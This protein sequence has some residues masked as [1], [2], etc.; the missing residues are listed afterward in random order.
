MTLRIV[1][2][3]GVQ[4]RISKELAIQ[5]RS[6]GADL[7]DFGEL[8]P[9][10]IA[11]RKRC[12]RGESLPSLAEREFAASSKLAHFPTA[13]ASERRPYLP[14]ELFCDKPESRRPPYK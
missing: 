6:V 1:I 2:V 9:A 13:V 3:T 12:G 8:S 5:G 11:T 4:D 14:A 7:R 10:R